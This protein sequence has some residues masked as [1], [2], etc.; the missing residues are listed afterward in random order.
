MASSNNVTTK[1]SRISLQVVASG[2]NVTTKSR[3]YDEDLLSVLVEFT[4]VG[5]ELSHSSQSKN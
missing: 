3:S 1:D 2:N 4:Y 5:L